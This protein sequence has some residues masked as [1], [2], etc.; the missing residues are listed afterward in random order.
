[1]NLYIFTSDAKQV[2]QFSSFG[3]ENQIATTKMHKF[4]PRKI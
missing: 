3:E 2:I 4:I 1:M